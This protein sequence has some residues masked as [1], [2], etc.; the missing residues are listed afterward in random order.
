MRDVLKTRQGKL[1]ARRRK[2]AAFL[3]LFFAAAAG[4]V[5]SVLSFVSQLDSLSIDSVAIKGNAR[6][7]SSALE[8]IALEE[9]AGN[10]LGFFSRR[11]IFLYPKSDIRG[12]VAALPLVKA[13]SV[14]RDGARTLLIS[15]TERDETALWCAGLTPDTGCFSM[16]DDGFIFD[17][18]PHE[19]PQLIK[20]RGLVASDPVGK[21]FLPADEFRKISF[22]MN[23]L[24]GLSIEPREAVF[25]GTSTAL[26][27]TIKLAGGGDLI[28]NSED[29]LSAVLSNIAAVISNKAV[30]PS[31]SE[32]LLNLDYM[33]LDIGNKVVYKLKP[34]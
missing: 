3:L 23:Q 24:S 18:Q 4:I 33:K 1:A 10:D 15:V 14:G 2:R 31:L 16:D 27:M 34:R 9:M 13:A 19:D 11:N 7:P 8:N 26:Y 32:F 5:F 21:H 6:I 28:V 17:G 12:A 30:A 20:Y 29:D 25:S 22:F